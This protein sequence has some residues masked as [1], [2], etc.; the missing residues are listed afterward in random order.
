M[1]GYLDR[2]QWH[3]QL[4]QRD[5][6]MSVKDAV[7]AAAGIYSTAPTSYLSFAA[8]VHGFVADDLDQALYRDRTLVRMGALRGSG[9]LIPVERI[10]AVASASDKRGWHEG[11]VD[12]AVGQKKRLQW[13]SQVLGILDGEILPAREIRARLGVSGEESE[14]LR[15][16]LASLTDSRLIVAASGVRSWRD[17]QHGYAIWDQWL[18]DHPVRTIDPDE[19]RAEV[20]RWYLHGHGPATLEDFSWWSGFNK[21][22]ARHALESVTGVEGDLYDIGD[23]HHA[24]P[25]SG[26]RLL[27]IWDTALVTQKTRRRMVDERLY[28]YVYDASG[29]VTS[30]VVLDGQ[31]IGIW[32]RGGD[33]DRFEIKVSF[34]AGS[35]PRKLVDREAAVIA[36]AVGAAD[37]SV[38]VV[39]GFTDLTQA[40]WNRF[41]SPLSG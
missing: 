15:F 5:R 35:G 31:V 6:S 22:N 4:L 29:N 16:L 32:D 13:T 1:A 27:P 11:A 37:S 18:P 2:E 23:R 21:T 26:L 40:S 20:A 19:A 33:A 3:R 30:T 10:D 36:A 24:D 38:E 25:P 12:K 39:D 28:P 8:R 34:F 9:F 41:M 17:N 7:E 14:P